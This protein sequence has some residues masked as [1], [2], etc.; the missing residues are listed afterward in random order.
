LPFHWGRGSRPLP[1]L[2]LFSLPPCF[3]SPAVPSPQA[4]P[5]F[6]QKGSAPKSKF[7]PLHPPC[8]RFFHLFP[9]FSPAVPFSF[10][11]FSSRLLFPQ[12]NIS[13]FPRSHRCS[14]LSLFPS[15]TF[16]RLSLTPS[17]RNCFGLPY[18][19]P[20][21]L[22]GGFFVSSPPPYP[23][24]PSKFFRW[25]QPL[26]GFFFSSFRN[27]AIPPCPSFSSPLFPPPLFLIQHPKRLCHTC[28]TGSGS[29]GPRSTCALLFSPHYSSPKIFSIPR[30]PPPLSAPHRSYLSPN[31]RDVA[32]LFFFFFPL[33]TFPPYSINPRLSSVSV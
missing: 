8:F 10:P 27:S 17:L 33:R 11:C 6:V 4:N 20:D 22:T 23:F 13:F 28:C 18:R 5:Q 24:P 21:T 3:F 12:S 19:A 7:T 32:L 25:A 14:P 1:F 15:F 16:C 26:V 9:C 29:A 31:L 30:A 2:F